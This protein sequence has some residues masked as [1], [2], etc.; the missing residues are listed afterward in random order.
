MKYTVALIC[1]IHTAIQ[2]FVILRTSSSSV[3]VFSSETHTHT[4][5][6]SQ[7]HN[8]QMHVNRAT[9]ALAL[10]E[11][12]LKC[13]C[14]IRGRGFITERW[15]K[16]MI[17]GLRLRPPSQRV[18]K[19]SSQRPALPLV[20]HNALGHSPALTVDQHEQFHAPQITRFSANLCQY[21]GL[22]SVDSLILANF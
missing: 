4:F 15:N 12:A 21:L 17:S 22:M 19:T 10:Q 16:K 1:N 8:R 2:I 11:S 5:I 7:T 9:I 14:E 20:A 3:A 18:N 6:H 13:R